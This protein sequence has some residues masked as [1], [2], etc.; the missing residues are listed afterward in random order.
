LL[1]VVV[2]ATA[3]VQMVT[4]AVELA[5][6]VQVAQ[7]HLLQLTF[8]LVVAMALF[9][10]AV[11][12]PTLDN[13]AMLDQLHLKVVVVAQVPRVMSPVS[14]AVQAAAPACMLVTAVALLVKEILVAVFHTT[15]QVAAAAARAPPPLTNK[16]VRVHLAVSL[17]QQLAVL[18]AVVV[19]VIVQ[20]QVATDLTVADVV[21]DNALVGSMPFIRFMLSQVATLGAYLLVEI[22]PAAAAVQGHIGLQTLAGSRDQDMAAPV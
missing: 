8:K 19:V 17:D 10:V 1:L 16:A 21:T 9:R 6:I 2:A 18:V 13:Q 4:V 11:T 7:H 12:L 15:G 20:S 14:Q 3:A 22:T 5:D